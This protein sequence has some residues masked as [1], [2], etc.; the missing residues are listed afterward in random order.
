MISNVQ[1]VSQNG[2]SS[3]SFGVLV[4]W[5]P[6][7]LASWRRP[8]GKCKIICQA[9]DI[10]EIVDILH[11]QALHRHMDKD[12]SDHGKCFNFNNIFNCNILRNIGNHSADTVVDRDQIHKTI[13]IK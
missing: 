12:R 10:V 1:K 8:S 4:S 7:I 6:R 2:N 11:G 9:R 5:H 13:N 3:C